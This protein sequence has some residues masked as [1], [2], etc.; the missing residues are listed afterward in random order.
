MAM[1][2][3]FSGDALEFGRTAHIIAWFLRLFG[4]ELQLETLFVI[5]LIARKAVHVITYGVLSLLVFRALRDGESGWRL[6]WVL[7]ALVISL[8][9][10]GIDE[11]RQTF[12]AERTGT[13]VDLLYDGAGAALAQLLLWWRMRERAGTPLSASAE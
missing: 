6:R 13:A 3:V 2:V 1:I 9:V 12:Y 5:N 11:Y 10:A 8:G 7:P 4:V